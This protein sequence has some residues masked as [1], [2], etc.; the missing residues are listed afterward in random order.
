MW[1]MESGDNTP[2]DKN[3]GNYFE[4]WTVRL[5]TDVSP[6]ELWQTGKS[7]AFWSFLPSNSVLLF[8]GRQLVMALPKVA[9]TSP[10]GQFGPDTPR[11]PRDRAHM[12][13]T[14]RSKPD[15]SPGPLLQG[16]LI[17]S[18]EHVME[19]HSASTLF[20]WEGKAMVFG[21]RGESGNWERRQE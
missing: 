19:K 20:K 13:Q 12:A 2:Q 16:Q 10:P 5:P 1:I 9:A 21:E 7:L 17:E 3:Q 11:A 8:Y 6:I 4:S 14:N 18:K 15:S